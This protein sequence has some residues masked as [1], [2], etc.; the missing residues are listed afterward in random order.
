MQDT[1]KNI[2]EILKE[3]GQATVDQ[4][5]DSLQNEHGQAITA[6]TVRHHL[7]I[8]Q[9]SGFISEPELRH[10]NSPGRPQHMY[11]LSAKARDL[12]PHNYRN[13]I[14]H[15]LD[16]L[17]QQ[18]PPDGVNVIFEGVAQSMASQ[19]MIDGASMSER[20]DAIID[21]LNTQGYNASWELGND[22]YL[23][24]T[25]NCPYH[26][27]SAETDTICNMDFKLIAALVGAAPRRISQQAHGDTSCTYLIPVHIGQGSKS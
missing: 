15:L 20:L 19:A 11:A 21:Y 24:H 3:R 2:L 9:Q 26:H 7:N 14:L 10:R 27:L 5:V 12:F 17:K 6:V 8:L 18:L 4:I 23:L 22:G 25:H 13:L 1:R 16:Q